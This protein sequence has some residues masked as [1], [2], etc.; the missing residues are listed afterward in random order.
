MRNKRSSTPNGLLALHARYV[1]K[2]KQAFARIVQEKHGRRVTE[3]DLPALCGMRL[4][5]IP[6]P[7][8]LERAFGYRGNMRYVAFH[9]SPRSAHI[10]HS[11]GGDHLPVPNPNDWITFVNHPAMCPEL[12]DYSTLLGRVGIN[13]ML[14]A[15][16]FEV[17]PEEQRKHYCERFYALVVD[18]VDR[19]LYVATW[20]QLKT[21]QPSAEPDGK[22]VH[23]ELP[24][25]MLVSPGN[26]QYAL[27]V[28]PSVLED[29]WGSLNHQLEDPSTQEQLALWHIR[30]GR[31][32]EGR[33]IL[34]QLANS[35]PERVETGSFQHALAFLHEETHNYHG[36]ASALE[37]YIAQ[38]DYVDEHVKLR[39]G[40]LYLQTSRH[41]D[42]LRWLLE[43]S[44]ASAEVA[45]DNWYAMCA[46][47]H[48]GMGDLEK[49]L[50]VCRSGLEALL[51]APDFTRA[52]DIYVQMAEIAAF[53][54]EYETAAA[55]CRKAVA[56]SLLDPDYSASQVA[57]YRL[58]WWFSAESRIANAARVFAAVV[59]NPASRDLAF[60]YLYLGMNRYTEAAASLKRACDKERSVE[61]L[62]LLGLSRLATR[63]RENAFQLF[64]ELTSCFPG[65]DRGHVGMAMGHASEGA[66]DLALDHC[67]A[68]IRANPRSGEAHAILSY[69]HWSAGRYRAAQE[70]FEKASRWGFPPHPSQ[71]RLVVSTICHEPRVE[72][73][74]E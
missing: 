55:N 43:A 27:P 72:D 19:R 10:G 41:E 13:R 67:E 6:C 31:P 22:E 24:N 65:D 74:R 23:I 21:F 53:Q 35:R 70:A 63:Q 48:V 46:R 5:S 18:R 30:E 51:S 58:G 71:A 20:R 34:E 28:E 14:T 38:C 52:G 66:N 60:G 16:E 68:A 62:W 1:A 37:K 11:D 2:M 40:E 12:H 44:A 69:L 73:S 36:A 7:P 47:C 33:S 8:M 56:A 45:D 39:L 49:G 15:E 3:R 4:L 9:Y 61:L 29:L 42:A 32:E 57:V 59:E 17:L 26:E 25:E 64:S 54:G 50:Q